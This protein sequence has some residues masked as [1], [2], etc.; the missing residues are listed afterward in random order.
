M[1]QIVAATPQM[2]RIAVLSGPPGLGKSQAAMHLAHPLDDGAAGADRAGRALEAVLVHGPDVRVD[3]RGP[4]AAQP[5]AG[6]RRVRPHRD[7]GQRGFHPR[8][9]RPGGDAD[10]L[11]RGRAAAAEAAL[12]P[13][14]LSRPRADLGQGGALR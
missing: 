7:Q 11:D 14:A 5:P 9:P 1:K 4:G 8:D 13:R 6:D 10:L 12:A 3:L 2:P